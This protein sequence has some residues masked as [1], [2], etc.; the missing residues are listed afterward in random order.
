[1]REKGPPGNPLSGGNRTFSR[2]FD[3][4]MTLFPINLHQTVES[5]KKSDAKK[6]P[7]TG[8]S[9]TGLVLS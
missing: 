4:I 7:C 3:E 8:N 9:L 2:L 1:M 6:N 5:F